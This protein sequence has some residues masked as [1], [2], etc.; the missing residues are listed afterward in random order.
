MW[1][2]QLDCF[3]YSFQHIDLR[4]TYGLLGSHKRRPVVSSTNCGCVVEI[5]FL[6]TWLDLTWLRSWLVILAVLL[7]QYTRQF[8]KVVGRLLPCLQ[9]QI[10]AV[11]SWGSGRFV[12]SC[13]PCRHKTLCPPAPSATLLRPRFPSLV[14]FSFFDSKS[15]PTGP[16]SPVWMNITNIYIC[17]YELCM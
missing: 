7:S 5:S 4:C 1:A 13:S 8:G 11:I 14:F 15:S 10:F 3:T 9:Y 12:V 6:V 17:L 16:T 2:C